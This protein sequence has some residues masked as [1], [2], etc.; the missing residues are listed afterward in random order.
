MQTKFKDLSDEDLIKKFLEGHTSYF[1]ALIKRHRSKWHHVIYLVVKDKELAEDLLQDAM[2]KIYYAFS[3][4]TYKEHQKFSSW[5]GRICKNL[6][7]DYLRTKKNRIQES[8][9][10]LEIRDFSNTI[11]ESIINEEN[12]RMLKNAINLLPPNQREVV[13]LRYYED[14]SFK[15]IAARNDISINTALGRMRYA[16]MNLQKIIGKKKSIY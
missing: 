4:N 3:E 5:A 12:Q 6:A 11:L 9:E 1:D 13:F 16:L 10:H 7:I 15:E 2:V 14:L 8:A